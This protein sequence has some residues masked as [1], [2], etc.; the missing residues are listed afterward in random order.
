[1]LKNRSIKNDRWLPVQTADS[2]GHDT[3]SISVAPGHVTLTR[4]E[5]KDLR[6]RVTNFGPHPTYWLHLKPSADRGQAIRFDPPDHM[7]KGKG[8]QTWKPERVARLEPGETA[9]LYA[10]IRLN[11]DLP[12]GSIK[13]GMY[14][15]A[16]TVVCAGN[17]E[18]SQTINV[19]VQSSDL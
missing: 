18:I 9:T 1:M 12:A 16:L 7:L 15:L 17:T 11:F 10:R 14:R 4:G 8:E 5:S 3:C 13:P 2:G 6:V 19:A